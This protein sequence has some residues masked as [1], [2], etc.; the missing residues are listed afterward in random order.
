MIGGA[1]V[2]TVSYFGGNIF[3]IQG[4][5]YLAQSPQLYKQMM[6]C[7]DFDRV[8]EIAPVFRAENSL[9]HRHMTEFMGLDLEMAFNDHY[10]EV[11][12][13]LGELFVE[14][15]KGLEKEYA[16]EIAT[17]DRQYPFEKF[18]YL[19]KTLILT[20]PEAVKMLRDSGL[21]GIIFTDYSWRIRRFFY[22][23]RT[24]FRTISQA[25][26]W[27]RLLYS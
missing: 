20:F 19:D 26:V 24:G 21:D 22:S 7:A 16:K 18:Q 11:L 6:I 13:M 1:N 23:N 25:E 27:Y 9:T 17:V 14:I 4:S 10:H 5:A 12:E 15:F 2:F 3:L 8:Y